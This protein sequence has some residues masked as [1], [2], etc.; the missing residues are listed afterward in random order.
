MNTFIFQ[1]VKE[2]FDLRDT[3]QPGMTDTWYATRYRNEMHPNDA[4]YFWMGGDDTI[5]GI[6]GWGLL[7]SE[8]YLK[9][10]WDS[11]GVDVVYRVKYSVPILAQELKMASRLSA[12]LIFRAPQ[13]T[14]FLLSTE[15]TSALAAFI[16]DRGRDV[17]PSSGG[18]P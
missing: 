6:Y 3:I 2:R 12:M 4:V 16:K 5:R 13:A 1:S 7:T 17:P 9:P 14:N 11:H 15:E 10:K 8:A 18:A